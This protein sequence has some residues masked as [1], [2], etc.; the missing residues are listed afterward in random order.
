MLGGQTMPRGVRNCIDVHQRHRSD[1][2]RWSDAEVQ[3]LAATL[4]AFPWPLNARNALNRG[5]VARPKA[6]LIATA[7]PA[8]ATMTPRQYTMVS[9][10]THTKNRATIPGCK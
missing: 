8:E 3:A 1:E 5:A 2:R 10:A 6:M 9:S 7:V 4:F